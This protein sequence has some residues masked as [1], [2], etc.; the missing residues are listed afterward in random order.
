M[1][2][3]IADLFNSPTEFTLDGE[4]FRV[5][6]PSELEMGEF[7]RWVEQLAFD[8]IN[9]RTYQSEAEKE[10]A[11]SRHDDKCAAGTYE[12]GGRIA[13][14]RTQTPKGLAKLLELVCRD[15]GLTPA[16][17]TKLV[18]LESRKIAFVL[19]SR[20]TQDPKVLEA[21]AMMLGLAPPN[22]TS[23]SN[24]ATRHSEVPA[25]SKPSDDSPTTS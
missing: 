5:R 9:R 15:Q 4:T 25:T 10:A 11:L 6:Q 19:V 8:A 1:P 2:G 18:D 14:E 17:A 12:W 20:L 7:Q 21:A 16:K 24:S 13:T 22:E 23:S 3:T